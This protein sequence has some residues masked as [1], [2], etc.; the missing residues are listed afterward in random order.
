MSALLSPFAFL[1]LSSHQP[2]SH[3]SLKETVVTAAQGNDPPPGIVISDVSLISDAFYLK[4]SM[5][6]ACFW[7]VVALTCLFLRQGFMTP[8]LVSNLLT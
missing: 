7:F 8:R 6:P 5:Y 2:F 3:H 1:G 4:A